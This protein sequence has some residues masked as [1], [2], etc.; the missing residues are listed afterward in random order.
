MSTKDTS[1]NDETQGGMLFSAM[2]LLLGL[3]YF[4]LFLQPVRSRF[5]ILDT[6]FHSI[7]RPED[8]PHTLQWITTQSAANFL[9]TIPFSS[10]L[11]MINR[12]E[13]V[14]IVIMINGIGDG[15]AEPVGIRFGK[16]KYQT[17]AFFTKKKF[18]RS[19]EGSACVFFTALA[20]V[21]FFGASFGPARFIIVLVSMPILMTLA[22]AF[23]PHSWD[24]PFL[25]AGG[26]VILFLVLQFVG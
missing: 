17:R 14:F 21:V 9:V 8:R 19:I 3:S 15:L 4:L 12:M 25:S 20:T 13:L 10:Y 24:N 7:D 2:G 16:H 18:T 22:E 5:G 11:M 26:Q 1:G 23:A 6:A